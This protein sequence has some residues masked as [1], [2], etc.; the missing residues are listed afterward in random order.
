MPDAQDADTRPL[1]RLL[2]DV[3]DDPVNPRTL[4]VEQLPNIPAY[5]FGFG[6]QGTAGRH[7]AEREHSLE[8]SCQPSFCMSRGGCADALES[9]ISV[10]LGKRGEP[11]LVSHTLPAFRQRL[12]QR[13]STRRA[14]QTPSLP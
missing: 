7:L 2:L 11:N 5:F 12:V 8:E 13:A 3:K 9:S 14:R 1:V 4:A 6:N 10:G